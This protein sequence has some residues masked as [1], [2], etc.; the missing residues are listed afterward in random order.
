MISFNIK[1]R[2]REEYSLKQNIYT[3]SWEFKSYM[4]YLG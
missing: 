4:G 1:R 2:T 3:W